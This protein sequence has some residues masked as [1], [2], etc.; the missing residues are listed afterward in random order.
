MRERQEKKI[1]ILPA[2]SMGIAIGTV[3][4]ENSDQVT[5]GYR[6]E[7]PCKRFLETRT[8]ARFPGDKLP[9]NIG[10]TTDLE[11]LVA[12]SDL[13]V[14]ATRARHL[15]GFFRQIKSAIRPDTEVIHVVKGLDPET[16][17]RISEVLSNEKHSL[18]N[19]ITVLSGPNYAH[20]IVRR[21]PTVTVIASTNQDLA[22]RLQSGLST[23]AFRP[24]IS[25]DMIGVELG[26][27]LKNPFAMA[28]GIVEGMRLG[29]NTSAAMQNRGLWEMMHLAVMLGAD[30]YT[31]I[32][33]AGAGDLSVSC[34]PP[35]RNYLAGFQIG[36]GED[37]QSLSESGIT[38]EGLD[39]VRS[40]VILA[41]QHK[42]EVPIL[43]TLEDI[44]YHGLTLDAAGKRLMSRDLAYAEPQPTMDPRLIR[45]MNRI[46]HVWGK[47]HRVAQPK[48]KF[49]GLW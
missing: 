20:E 47:R 2:G 7:E 25:D 12:E 26:G 1:A 18:R 24:Y 30:Q 17:Q 31:I 3:F 43:E 23:S 35:G 16:N 41:R 15:R 22:K 37:P 29:A 49:F 28:V 8:D 45:W 46:F 48:P 19:H 38:I 36:Q 34:K 6:S 4:A 33:P 11:R 13:V 32:G 21:L 42:V 9:G 5:L 40:A 10:A 27:A 39:S 14:F 44:L